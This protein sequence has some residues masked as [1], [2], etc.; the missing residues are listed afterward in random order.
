MLLP[1][2]THPLQ[3]LSD[4][5][6]TQTSLIKRS[7]SSQSFYALE[8]YQTLSSLQ[9]DWEEVTGE[10]FGGGE[11][12]MVMQRMVGEGAAGLRQACLRSFP[13]I[14]VDV[15]APLSGSSRDVGSSSVADITY[16]VRVLIRSH[17][18][19]QGMRLIVPLRLDRNISRE[20]P[21][22]RSHRHRPPYLRRGSQLAHGRRSHIPTIFLR[23]RRRDP[24]ALH[25]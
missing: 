21:S 4:L 14:L 9:Q 18:C 11:E 1:I 24:P 5:L 6:S 15:R 2:F 17:D 3:I 7:L 23:R 8:L 13:E 22:L 12:E 25:R 20:P 19:L 10:L 16:T